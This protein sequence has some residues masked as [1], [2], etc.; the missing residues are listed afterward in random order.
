MHLEYSFSRPGSA[1]A[2][3]ARKDGWDYEK[4]EW[5]IPYLEGELDGITTIR[6]IL[7]EGLNP[8]QDLGWTGQSGDT[9]LD[10]KDRIIA[11]QKYNISADNIVLTG[12]AQHSNFLVCMMSLN[13]GDVV[14]MAQPSWYQ[15]EPLCN[16]IGARVK[17]VDLKED[18]GWRWDLD[19]LNE[20]V[21]KNTK[22]MCMCNPNN[23]TGTIYDEK[24]MKSIAEIAKDAGA[25][26]LVD[27][28]FKGFEWDKPLSTSGVNVYENAATTGSVSKI[29]SGDGLR[30][31]WIAS[32]NKELL[33]QC[34]RLKDIEIE[35]IN[36]LGTI[37]AWAAFEHKKYEELLERHRAHGR[38]N[39]EIVMEWMRK[40]DFFTWIPPEA[41]FLSFPKYAYDISSRDFA[42]RLWNEYRTTIC[43]GLKYGVEKHLRLGYGRA[44][45]DNI[46]KG[47]ANL[48]LFIQKLR[49]EKK[50]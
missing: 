31:G 2:Y 28:V 8:G 40:Q 27:E 45:P 16:M 11:T 44:S 23:P 42:N 13:P 43:P 21:G 4:F 9:Y 37:L 25:V 33:T 29:L 17:I 22:L 15:W 48:D 20:A 50:Q 26:L 5:K 10:L 12:G 34:S 49:N 24:E 19:E 35:H 46:R 14:V 7:P 1:L 39:R 6:D 18:K 41:G 30:V 32:Q 36:V 38:I 3:S 47:L